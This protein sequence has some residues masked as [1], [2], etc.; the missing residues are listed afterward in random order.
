MQKLWYLNEF[1]HEAEDVHNLQ[2]CAVSTSGGG[3]Q[4]RERILQEKQWRVYSIWKAIPEQCSW[5]VTVNNGDFRRLKWS[6]VWKKYLRFFSH[7]LQEKSSYSLILIYII[8]YIYLIYISY[9][10]R[11]INLQE[12]IKSEEGNQT[13]KTPSKPESLTLNSSNSASNTWH[14]GTLGC[15][16][17][18]AGCCRC[19]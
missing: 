11:N 9:C 17:S 7:H 6:A 13:N 12:K 10:I 8:Y 2:K 19:Q 4:Q 16:H 1:T 3:M 5:I 14:W 15:H 18:R